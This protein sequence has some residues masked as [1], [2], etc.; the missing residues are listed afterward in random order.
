[1][2]WTQIPAASNKT[3]LE[4]VAATGKPRIVILTKRKRARRELAPW[5]MPHAISKPGS[6]RQGA[7]RLAGQFFPA[8]DN[9]AGSSGKRFINPSSSSRQFGNDH[10]RQDL[11][12]LNEPPLYHSV[13]LEFLL[14]QL[15]HAKVSQHQ[16]ARSPV[17]VYVRVTN[18]VPYQA[19]KCCA[20]F[21]CHIPASKA[22]SNRAFSTGFPATSILELPYQQRRFIC[23]TVDLSIVDE[24]GTRR[25]RSQ[26]S[27]DVWIG[28]GQPVAA[29]AS[30]TPRCLRASDH[31]H[32]RRHSCAVL[33]G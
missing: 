22:Y 2:T 16:V 32:F 9:P 26:A 17:T 14:I 4:S 10:W 29:H 30:L 24:T 23:A 31:D 19:T 33:D 6:G 27:V 21:I 20:T 18:D 3:L 12:L 15:S 13:R 8:E 28:G 25:I 1:M 7:L 5:N 11:P